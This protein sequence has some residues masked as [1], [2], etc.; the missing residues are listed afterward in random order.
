MSTDKVIES[1][2]KSVNFVKNRAFD[3]ISV[4]IIMAMTALS[5]GVLELRDITF[6][7][8]LNIAMECI[9][10]YI[11]ATM[12]SVNYYTKGS[13][14][15]KT[16]EAFL[17]A[18]KY[19][20]EQVNKLTGE[21]M[22]KLPEF[23]EEYNS[24]A[25]KAVK[26]RLLKSVAITWEVYDVGTTDVKPLKIWTKRE[27]DAK[28][29]KHIRKVIIKC[30]KAKVKGINHNLLLGNI[31]NSDYTDLGHNEK[32]LA[33]LRTASFAGTYV[34]SIAL[35]TLIGVKN[36]F[37]WGWMGAFLTLFKT[38]YV[39]CGAYMKYFNGYE[40]ISTDVVNHLYRKTDV[41]KEFYYWYELQDK[42]ND[43]NEDVNN[44]VIK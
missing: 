8:I 37:Q 6:G 42:K 25:L 40:D 43:V 5:L 33:R 27:L 1:K 10:F 18:V 19:Y 17:N 15:A 24:K 16:K 22:S 36:V 3:L 21:Q 41:I 28:Y 44:E 2:N 39:A 30:N 34:I 9:P 4:G 29:G 35:I 32:E 11:S 20:S 23:C 31:D 14:V 38:L 7:E 12:L 13:F 26:E